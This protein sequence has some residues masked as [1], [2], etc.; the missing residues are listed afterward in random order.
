METNASG[1]EKILSLLPE[2][3]EEKARETGAFTRSRKIQNAEEL[4]R[5]NLLYLTSGGSFGRT[6]AMLKLTGKTSL[7]KNA[8]YERVKKS[9]DWLQWMCENICRQEGQLVEA[10]AWLEGHRVCLVDATDEAKRGSTTTDYRMHYCVELFHLKLVE[11]HLTSARVGEKLSNFTQFQKGDIVVAD[12]AYPSIKGMVHL[13]KQ[14]VDYVLRLRSN[15]F[16]LYNE[17]GERIE[18]SEQLEDLDVGKNKDLSL[19]CRNGNAMHPVRIC[20]VRK[21][22]QAERSGLTKIKASNN[23]KMRG[24]VSKKQAIYNRYVVVITSL[25]ETISTDRVLELYR[26]RWQIELVFKRFKSIFDFDEMPSRS[27]TAIESWFY[28]K[29]LVAAICEAL[30]NQGRFSPF[31]QQL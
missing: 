13:E 22:E 30:V 19:Y 28:G 16:Y 3:W 6:S 31:S 27:T 4:L 23:K 17:K 11:M 1:F 7:N 18:L 25:P 21:T 29:L 20:A 12:R 24:L 15:A 5:M 14:K 26:A 8:V 2:G 9:S 10:P